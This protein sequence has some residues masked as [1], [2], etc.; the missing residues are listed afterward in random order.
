MATQITN[1]ARLSYLYGGSTRGTATSNVA[2][3][4]LQDS[5]EATKTS[6]ETSYR[7][8]DEITYILT[9]S[10]NC[11]SGEGQVT[12]A[13]NLGSYTP[14]G[15]QSPV[16]PLTYTGPANL[17]I[18]GVLSTSL[19]VDSS[20][21]TEVK[22][23]VPSLAA[24]SN[25]IIVYKAQVNEFADLTSGAG[26]E[27]TAT[28]SLAGPCVQTVEVSDTLPVADYADVSIVKS[29]SACPNGCNAITYT[30]DLYNYG[31]AEA[32]NVVLT[33][34]FNPVPVITGITVDGEEF[35]AANYDFSGGTLTL[36]GGTASETI[37]VPA[38]TITAACTGTTVVPGTAEIV[39]SGTVAGTPSIPVAAK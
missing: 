6:L 14:D 28:F 5:L 35:G 18:D 17:Y 22:F 34:L 24:G 33:D 1:Q 16:N 15:C 26:I 36:P 2:T 37:T 31:N 8:N 13:D 32:T 21:A 7:A 4:T 30:F 3:A 11:C 10:N 12:I 23:T 9:L 19:Q 20:D 29:M 38:A 25:A 27:N 39:V